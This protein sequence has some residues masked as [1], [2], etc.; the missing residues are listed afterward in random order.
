VA[1]HFRRV[2]TVASHSKD[3]CQMSHIDI[4][5]RHNLSRKEAQEAAD[6]LA[7]DLAGKFDID[8]AWDGDHIHFDRPGVRGT[9]TVRE[10]EIIIDARL[11]LMLMFLKPQIESEVTRYLRDHFGCTFV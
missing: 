7:G 2:Y 4:H 5:A 6:Q 10:K 1:R 9:I 11:G 8:Y 3:V